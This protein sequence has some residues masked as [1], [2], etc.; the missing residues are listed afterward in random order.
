[1]LLLSL[2]Y[3]YQHQRRREEPDPRGGQRERRWPLFLGEEAR[4][5][6]CVK[7]LRLLIITR[8]PKSTNPSP[9]VLT[10]CVCYSPQMSS[11]T[12]SDESVDSPQPCTSRFLKQRHSKPHT[13]FN[14]K[15]KP[16]PC[17]LFY[18]KNTDLKKKKKRNSRRSMWT[19]G[20]IPSF[21]VTSIQS[22][23]DLVSSLPLLSV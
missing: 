9:S 15:F 21:H 7:S 19:R 14:C 23:P 8:R 11:L 5:E 3:L 17:C 20:V 1:M 10:L 4:G 2:S 13:W 12:R 16:L 6:R 22:E 18:F